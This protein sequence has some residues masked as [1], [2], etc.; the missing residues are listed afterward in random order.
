MQLQRFAIDFH[1][2]G[3]ILSSGIDPCYPL[4]DRLLHSRAK[5]KVKFVFVPKRVGAV[6]M[7]FPT[8]TASVL[9][10]EQL[11]YPFY[12]WAHTPPSPPA[13]WACNPPQPFR[14]ILRRGRDGLD[15][16]N[17]VGITEHALRFEK[18]QYLEQQ[19]VYGGIFGS[20]AE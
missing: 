13:N 4:D 14:P 3:Y 5:Q 20:E 17:E 8:R 2:D 6:I 19:L 16:L 11:Q 12:R 7:T 10:I 15:A 18:V 1:P 9:R